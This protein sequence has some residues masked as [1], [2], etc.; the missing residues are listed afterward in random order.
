[1]PVHRQAL[2]VVWHPVET[3]RRNLNKHNLT[4]LPDAIFLH[5]AR[6]TKPQHKATFQR[7]KNANAQ[8]TIADE[9]SS[10][11]PQHICRTTFINMQPSD[12]FGLLIYWQQIFHK[13]YKK[14]QE[15]K[16]PQAIQH[17]SV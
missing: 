5:I 16:V 10:T 8:P 6:L 15:R 2:F 13:I 3:F 17:L 14:T 4:M 9:L 7:A 12:I 11:S 1:M